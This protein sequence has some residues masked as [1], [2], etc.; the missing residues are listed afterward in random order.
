MMT[1]AH[2]RALPQDAADRGKVVGVVIDAHPQCLDHVQPANRGI[3]DM[4]RLRS[5]IAPVVFL[6]CGCA[7]CQVRRAGARLQLRGPVGRK[8]EVTFYA[9]EQALKRELQSALHRLVFEEDVP[10]EDIVVLTPRSRTTSALWRWPS[11][12]NLRLTEQWPPRA[13]EVY[14]T[15]V[16]LFKGLESPVVI[17]A[18]LYPSRNQDI[19]AL[20]Y[21]GCSRARNHLII[22]AEEALP[23]DIRGRL[24]GTK[25]R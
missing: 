24:P 23:A 8:P 6:R 17:L 12:G 21:V 20:L 2:R 4:T 13:N 7:R 1:A 16:Y 10:A 3:I 19:E 11:L 5:I 18:E 22:F 9:S 14:C 15:S 25:D